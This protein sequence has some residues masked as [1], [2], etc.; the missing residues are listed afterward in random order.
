M[1]ICIMDHF[2]VLFFFFNFFGMSLHLFLI[3]GFLLTCEEC[4]P[5]QLRISPWDIAHEEL[6]VLLTLGTGERNDAIL[7]KV[8]EHPHGIIFIKP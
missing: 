1:P 3:F 7:L 2:K 4:F 8:F 6:S 5:K